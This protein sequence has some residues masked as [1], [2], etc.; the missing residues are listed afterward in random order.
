MGVK[1][2][3]GCSVCRPGVDPHASRLLDLLA[4][5]SEAHYCSRWLPG[6]ECDLYR[7]VFEG[8]DAE[9]GTAVVLPETIAE[10]RRLAEVSDSWWQWRTES[11]TRV[12]GLSI[13]GPHRISLAEARERFGTSDAA[14]MSPE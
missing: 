12:K 2:C 13:T 14:K 6:L 11:S 5:I 8:A 1:V 9:Y 10:L 7:I 3:P 4:E